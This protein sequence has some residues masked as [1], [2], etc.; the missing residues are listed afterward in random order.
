MKKPNF[1]ILGAP[2]CGTTS[3]SHYLSEHQNIFF[4]DPKEPHYFST[5]F[6]DEYR[7]IITEEE[8]LNLFSGAENYKAAGEGSVWYLYSKDAVPNILEYNPDAKFIVMT[9]EP[10]DMF[11]SLHAQLLHSLDEDIKDIEKAW[12]IQKER[13]KGKYIPDKCREP[14][15]L[16]Y[17]EV[18]NLGKQINRLLKLVPDKKNIKIIRLE[19]LKKNPQRVYE[20]TLDFLSVERDG[21]QDFP[22]YNK[23]SRLK[24]RKMKQILSFSRDSAIKQISKYIKKKI[25]I[26]HWPLFVALN[27]WNNKEFR[28]ERLPKDLRKQLESFFKNSAYSEYL[29]T[30]NGQLNKKL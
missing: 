4:S 6:S 22:V 23:N 21:R 15:L 7:L 24:N 9:R 8:Y 5:D 20:E 10:V 18:C 28:R 27:K 2:K 3:L 1:F 19:D 30:L 25:G 29:N 13:K 16:Q 17:G 12:K 14:K 11:S 26:K